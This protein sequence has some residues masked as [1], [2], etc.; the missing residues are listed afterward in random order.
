MLFVVA[1]PLKYGEAMFAINTKPKLPVRILLVFILLP[2]LCSVAQTTSIK[3]K[4]VDASTFEPLAYANVFFKGTQLGTTTDFEGNFAIVSDQIG[5]SLTVSLLGY[6]QSSKAVQR[7]SEQI[8]NYSLYPSSLSLSE[9]IITPGENPAHIIMRKVWA[10]SAANNIDKLEQYSVDTYTKTSVY[11][12]Q[13]RKEGPSEKAGGSGVFA[14]HAILP[15]EGSDAALPVYMSETSSRNYYLRSPER[16]KVLVE[17]SNTNSLIDAD[18]A[19]VTQLIQKSSKFN[20]YENNIRLLERNFVSPLS[21]SG[22]FFYKYYL[23]DSLYIDD[24]YCYELRVIPRRSEDL[25]FNGTIWITASGFALKRLMLEVGANVNFNFVDRIRIMQDLEAVGDGAWMPVK[26]RF[27]ADAV[28]IFVSSYVEYSNFDSK[29]YP[30]GFYDREL[31]VSEG[32]GEKDEKEWEKLRPRQLDSHDL[33]TLKGIEELQ[34]IGSVKFLSSLVNMSI[35]AYYNFGDFE[36]GPWLLLYNHNKVE[37]HRFRLGFRTNPGFSQKWVASGYLAYGTDD[38]KLKYEANIE[39]FLSRKSW[40]KLGLQYRDDVER[41]GAK[42]EFYSKSSFSSFAS[43]FGG[44]DKLISTRLLRGWFETDVFRGFT[45][46]IVFLNKWQTP[47]SPDLHFAYFKD[48]ER[49]SPTSDLTISEL[50]FTSVYQPKATFIIDKNN[51][52]PVSFNN[53]PTFSASYTYG[54]N[55]LLNSDFKYHKASVGME[56]NILLGSLGSLSYNLS[57]KKVFSPLPYPLLNVF[58][59]NESWFRTSNTFNM[60]SYGEYVADQSAE[61]FITFRQ[62]G[63]ILDKIPLIK[64][65]NWRSVATAAMAYGSF[66]EKKNGYYDTESNKQGI[67]LRELPGGIPSTSFKTLDADSPYLEVSYGIENIFR[68]FR[69]EAFHRLTQLQPDAEGN[70]PRTTAIKLSAQFRF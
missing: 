20:F 58:H 65:L 64:K 23:N 14:L 18:A 2:G 21:S 24:N 6:E 15:E 11:L 12:R 9:V 34:E 26:S 1:N 19:I 8:L 59:A 54:F 25:A 50:N 7:G 35:K 49:T 70:K 45:Q 57:M 60:M 68:F 36:L 33:A 61:L 4:V 38:E 40:T 31:E 53:A 46:K 42:D 63:F 3:G 67:L 30:L 51:R 13:L 37:G 62:D 32:A 44:T 66:D 5:D 29:D 17:A 47:A 39:R 56:Q 48:K 43:S 22:L 55:G 16:E 27:M 69:I 52:F 10:N 28:N 41:L